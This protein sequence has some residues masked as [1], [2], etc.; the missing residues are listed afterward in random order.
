MHSPL[1]HELQPAPIALRSILIAIVC[2]GFVA[3][4]VSMAA[5]AAAAPGSLDNGFG[6]NGKVITDFGQASVANAIAVQSDQKVVA[7]GRVGGSSTGDFGLARYHDDGTPDSGFGARGTV[8]TPLTDDADVARAVAVQPDG[9]IVVGGIA[10][11]PAGS[12]VAGDFALARYNANG[13]LDR[14]FAGGKVRTDLSGGL[15]DGIRAI[16]ILTDGK[17]LAVG[18]AGSNVGM[19]RYNRDGTLDGSFGV[20]GKAVVRIGTAGHV[21]ALAV[22]ENGQ[23]LV[24]GDATNIPTQGDFLLARFNGDGSLDT[25]FGVGGLVTTDFAGLNDLAFGLTVQRDGKILAVGNTNSLDAFGA[26]GD[27]G[28]GIARYNR[29]GTP[30]RGFGAGGKVQINPTPI[31]DGLRGVVVESNGRIV[32]GGFIGESRASFQ[33]PTIGDFGLARLNA[34]GSLDKSFGS[35]GV[36]RT[37]FARGGDGGRALVMHRNRI[38]AAGGASTNH[39]NFGLARYLAK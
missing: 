31:A 30:D 24:A 8:T 22:L 36:V 12:N 39:L 7:V 28:F 27:V 19:A 2:L 34:D 4:G 18:A 29:D 25:S 21:F 9:K 37:D 15:G 16:A 32:V 5:P 1:H 11:D 20:G 10:G 26:S 23:F 13:T 17:I 14:A 3:L 6:K 35:A 33:D 38:L